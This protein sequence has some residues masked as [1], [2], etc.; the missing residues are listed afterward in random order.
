M[1]ATLRPRGPRGKPL[2]FPAALSYIGR[3]GPPRGGRGKRDMIFSLGRTAIVLIVGLTV[4]YV[5]LYFYFRSGVKMRLEED[6]V[7]QGRPGDRADWVDERLAPHA[8][9]IRNRLL[10]GVYVLPLAALSVYVYF[11]N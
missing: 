5:S 6:W 8:L 11:T 7:M 10:L 2:P 9:R 4:V 1:A 3:K